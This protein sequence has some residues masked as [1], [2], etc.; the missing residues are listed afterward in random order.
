MSFFKPS[1]SPWSG[2]TFRAPKIFTTLLVATTVSISITPS[3]AQETT[4]HIEGVIVE[5]AIMHPASLG[6]RSYL[7]FRIVNLSPNTIILNR[8]RTSAANAVEILMDV[9]G[10]GHRSV[11]NV[12][13]LREETLNLMT[14]H[15]RVELNQLTQELLPG[16][17][18]E[19]EIEF[20]NFVI[21]AVADV[22]DRY[23]RK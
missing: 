7:C 23:R 20:Q 5:D 8:V 9:P 16:T 14:S 6:E 21:S 22:Y 13:I 15:I 2:Q 19:F 12:P 3:L 18:I 17:E 1:L 10:P 4:E 11:S